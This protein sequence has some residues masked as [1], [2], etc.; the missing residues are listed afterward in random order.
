VQNYP[1]AKFIKEAAMGLSDA[2]IKLG[3]DRQALDIVNYIEKRWPRYY[4]EYPPLLKLLGDVSYRN[5]DYDRAKNYYWTLY[6]IDPQSE[7]MDIVLAR[8]GDIYAVTEQW[9]A[10]QE[11]YERAARLYPDD[12]GGLIAQMRLAEHGVYDSPS[13]AAQFTVFDRPYSLKPSQI[14]DKIIREHPNSPLAP[15]AQLKL[16]M[17][18][19]WNKNYRDALTDI[20][21]FL[22]KYPDDE[23]A[24]RAKE[25]GA[26][27]LRQIVDVFVSQK[28]FLGAVEVWRDYPFLRQSLDMLP[29]KTIIGL[30]LCFDNTANQ[31]LAIQLLKPFLEGPSM[32][33]NSEEALTLALGVYMDNRRWQDILALA[34]RISETWELSQKAQEELN[35]ALAL[36]YENLDKP[37]MATPLWG[38]IAQ[39]KQLDP[40]RLAYSQYFLAFEAK[41]EG[42]L[43][44]AYE[45]AQ[46]SLAQL[47]KK[48]DPEKVKDLLNLLIDVSQA[49]GRPRE[50]LKWALDYSKIIERSD[51]E[52]PA[53]RYRLA[54]IYKNLADTKKWQS[55][56]E[57]L[58]DDMP[59]SFYGRLAASDLQT[60]SIEK[61]AQDFMPLQGL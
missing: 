3:H 16:A 48:D 2:L 44:K 30:A 31:D 59:D 7:G 10:A 60:H 58:R 45:Y 42:D 12:T 41:N 6:N 51:P 35:Y 4:L 40:G 38:R 25:V 52:W 33:E 20:A 18:N 13:I 47:M 57:Q 22:K 36:A 24:K 34:N 43:K 32:P 46:D 28:N 26:D 56:L 27:A 1:D 8:I 14:Y 49:S 29:A 61:S 39:D 50:A 15:L 19:L 11:I 9:K 21:D 37:E 5:K 23:L 53:L 54:R 55:I 17:W